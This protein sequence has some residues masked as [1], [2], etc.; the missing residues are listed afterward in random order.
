MIPTNLPEWIA[1]RRKLHQMAQAETLVSS[2]RTHW[3]EW[4]RHMQE[5]DAALMDVLEALWNERECEGQP[6][7]SMRLNLSEATAK[8]EAAIKRLLEGK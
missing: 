3:L 1:A 2:A 5:S 7:Q 6:D 8:L 4:T